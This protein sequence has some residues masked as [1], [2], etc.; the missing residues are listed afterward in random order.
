[1]CQIPIKMLKKHVI[2]IPALQ[3]L[4]IYSPKGYRK[5]SQR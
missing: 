4:Q 1:M 2:R 5:T 3:N